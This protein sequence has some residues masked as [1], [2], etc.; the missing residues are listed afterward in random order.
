MQA[1][2]KKAQVS[3]LPINR[4]SQK[5]V[6]FGH[7]PLRKKSWESEHVLF[8]SWC[9][10][11]NA[12]CWKSKFESSNM[13]TVS[14]EM[15][16]LGARLMLLNRCRIIQPPLLPKY[17]AFFGSH[18]DKNYYC[19]AISQNYQWEIGLA[20]SFHILARSKMWCWHSFVAPKD[21]I[22]YLVVIALLLFCFIGL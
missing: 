18:V 19:P 10:I 3:Y 20:S 9:W 14:K 8:K 16:W 1:A 7:L 5:T 6:L 12:F 4:C 13:A 17:R 11:A 2:L 22:W 21:T 15:V